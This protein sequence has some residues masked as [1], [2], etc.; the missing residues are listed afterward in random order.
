VNHR[1]SITIAQ[2]E[3]AYKTKGALVLRRCRLILRDDEDA[4]DMLHETF[5]RLLKYNVTIDTE[6]ISLG[7]L[8]RTAER[9][10]FDLMRSR[11]R[12]P[13]VS[14]GHS[15]ENATASFTCETMEMSEL[16]NN[17]FHSLDEKLRTLALLYFV[18]GLTQEQ[19]AEELGWSRKTIGHKLMKL[20]K[21]AEKLK[22]E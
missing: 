15:I 10:C 11:K 14:D 1:E 21:K 16:L 8:Y 3:A 9:C 5:R 4:N 2:I 18:D 22:K 19:I 13:T 17:Y 6:E 12:R 7:F 20:K